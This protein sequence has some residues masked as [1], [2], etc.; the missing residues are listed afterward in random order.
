MKRDL[1]INEINEYDEIIIRQLEREGR[2]MEEPVSEK[3]WV[4]NDI[5]SYNENEY[6]DWTTKDFKEYIKYLEELTGLTSKLKGVL[7]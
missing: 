2:Y 1:F 5:L 6:E 7:K 4:H 3:E